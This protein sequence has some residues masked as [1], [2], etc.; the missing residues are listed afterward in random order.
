MSSLSDLLKQIQSTL[1]TSTPS[2]QETL[3]SIDS[4]ASTLSTHS[5]PPLER[6]RHDRLCNELTSIYKNIHDS[7]KILPFFQILHALLP[8]LTPD[9]I[10]TKW[11][12]NVL[13]PIL[14]SQGHTK[15]IV[16][17]TKKI[18]IDSMTGEGT[19][20]GKFVECITERYLE[21]S[22]MEG[23]A[24]GEEDSGGEKREESRRFWFRNL[25]S[26]L[27]GFGSVRTKNFFT[28]LNKYFLEK[29]TR[30]QVLTLLGIFIRQQAINIHQI[31]ETSLLESILTSLQIDSS[32][33]LLSLSLTTLIM[34]MPHIST[35]VVE[36][37]P[38]LYSVFVRILCWDK[39]TRHVDIDFGNDD[40]EDQIERISY[41]IDDDEETLNAERN[42]DNIDW[43]RFDSSFDTAPS[44]P[45]NCLPLFTFLYGMFPCNTVKFLRDPRRWFA[46]MNYTPLYEQ[47]DENII[48]SRSL[49]L[50]RRHTIHPKL[51]LNDCER[52]LSDTSRWKKLEPAEVVAECVSYDIENTGGEGDGNK[53]RKLS[54]AISMQDIIGIHQ[55]LKSGADIVVGD[56]PWSSTIFAPLVP[57]YE[58]SSL[59]L[60]PPLRP[61]TNTQAKISFLQREIMLLRNE[62][63]FELY[64]KQQ[65]LQHIGRLHHD[66]VVDASVEAERQNL[67][68]TCK[69]L[70]TQIKQTQDA[71]DKQRSEMQSSRKKQV[72]WENELNARI[73]K[74]RE[75]RKEWENKVKTCQNQVDDAKTANKLIREE[76]DKARDR[77]FKLETEQ[78]TRK[79]ELTK[80]S[81]YESQIDRLAKKLLNWQNKSKEFQEQE[82]EIEKLVAQAKKME[83][84]S[85]T[86]EQVMRQLN[87]T[88]S[89]QS[90]IIDDLK[91][92]LQQQKTTNKQD[93]RQGLWVIERETRAAREYA[94]VSQSYDLARKRNEELEGTVLELKAKIEMMSKPSL[95]QPPEDD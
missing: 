85:E 72:E 92:K 46:E 54:Q 49:P 26:L 75:E 52:E 42:R 40:V 57:P 22:A 25:E 70:R 48:R 34:L 58:Q 68:R 74:F 27:R 30:L 94:K 23:N 39:L 7:N 1:T 17:E 86:N 36:N 15:D 5:N 55:A 50:F 47:I 78:E 21:E 13:S 56:D 71:L 45:P 6:D 19:K 3:N 79:A 9:V 18:V 43:Q 89:T 12:D 32:T 11:W 90:Q 63:N 35:S 29:K 83:V 14:Q 10:I 66:H 80:L 2:L 76:L 82:W 33:T 81:E 60:S 62:L 38:Q 44:T 95:P 91:A 88:I 41:R 93:E 84:V 16:E 28:L 53:V 4:F 65:H 64:L 69:M 73:K 8:I 67:H 61:S 24:V 37:L 77:V 59:P 87:E 20:V 51:I 31:L